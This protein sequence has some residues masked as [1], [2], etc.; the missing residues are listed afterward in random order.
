MDKNELRPALHFYE[1]RFIVIGSGR[2]T[3][4]YMLRDKNTGELSHYSEY[5]GKKGEKSIVMRPFAYPLAG[6]IE[7]RVT[8]ARKNFPED[9]ELVY[10]HKS[11]PLAVL[12]KRREVLAAIQTIDF[13][14][15]DDNDLFHIHATLRYRIGSQTQGVK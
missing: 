10:V 13:S 7:Y 11:S 1:S 4:A 14:K 2:S 5:V 12:V 8:G 9:K 6:V 15:L 3:D